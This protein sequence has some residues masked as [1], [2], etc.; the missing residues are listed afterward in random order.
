[1]TDELELRASARLGQVLRGKYR[2]ERV[3]GVGGMAVV[4]VATHRNQKQFAVKMLHPEL[5][6]REDIR[7]RFL[8]EG[9]AAN[10]VKH[11]AAVAVLDEDTAEDGSAF[12]VMELL[13]GAPVEAIWD[14]RGGRLP[15]A[16]VL[17]VAY[18]LLDVL[19]AA[20]AKG[21]IHRD[22]KPANLFVTTEGQLKVLDFGIARVRDLAVG[23]AQ[24]TGTGILLGTPAFM[25]PEQALAKA[26]EIDAA[27]DIWAVGATMFS[28]F[29]GKMV[30]EGETAP[31]LIVKVA[32]T[33]APSLSAL[34]PDA[35]AP[36][37]AVVD[38]A[39]AFDKAARWPSAVQ[40]RE[41]VRDAH[42]LADGRLPSRE[43]LRFAPSDAGAAATQHAGAPPSRPP[44]PPT[45]DWMG[46]AAGPAAPGTMRV[47]GVLPTPGPLVPQSHRSGATPWGP[48]YA[49]GPLVPVGATTAQPISST[50]SRR[51][52][53]PPTRRG[54]LGGAA[55]A[56]A[57]VAA[58]I[59]WVRLHEPAPSSSAA[60]PPIVTAGIVASQ[61]PPAASPQPAAVA[62]AIPPSA[63]GVAPGKPPP[64][65][66]SRPAP[67]QR[68]ASAPKPDP[69]PFTASAAAPEPP[70]PNPSC[71]PN[72]TLDAAGHKIFKPYCFG[73][74]GSP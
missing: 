13:E 33:Q 6:L 55:I 31:Q 18:Q 56:L 71:S 65:P 35:P 29:T 34:A 44:T 63:S 30:H 5:S 24:A 9:Y 72:Y 43:S 39:L 19:A 10:S 41:A 68:P 25:S 36:L 7:T 40:M 51:P 14:R 3:L 45:V 61:A 38:R 64:N 48:P 60:S 47:S 74:T 15:A 59:A 50:H 17:A 53:P 1:V 12:L 8:R 20:H 66:S 42:L 2:L 32:T 21:I 4:Y 70:K 28:L 58:A 52:A 22:I 57:G 16:Y 26:S 73:V 23:S 49:A 67:A 54:V 11:P 37:V 27:T 62:P 46:P 69:A